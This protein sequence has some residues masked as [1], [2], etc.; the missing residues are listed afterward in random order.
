MAAGDFPASAHNGPEQ[1]YATALKNKLNHYCTELRQCLVREIKT[2]I[3]EE[4]FDLAAYSDNAP[5]V[6]SQE[7]IR[8]ILSASMTAGLFRRYIEAARF[9]G[10]PLPPNT[11]DAGTGL[12]TFPTVCAGVFDGNVHCCAYRFTI[13]GCRLPL[14]QPTRHYC[15]SQW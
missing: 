14:H 8:D 4:R 3:K 15:A 11:L 5:C 7:T 12:F 1:V 2:A 10:M 9:C 13:V 6:I